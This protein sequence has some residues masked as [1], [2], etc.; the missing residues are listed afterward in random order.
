MVSASNVPLPTVQLPDVVYDLLPDHEEHEL[1]YVEK[2]T[3]WRRVHIED[4]E[5]T[6]GKSDYWDC[7]L[8]EIWCEQCQRYLELEDRDWTF[9]V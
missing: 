7:E 9:T 4:G 8:S 2:G 3:E 1:S 6:I 5:I